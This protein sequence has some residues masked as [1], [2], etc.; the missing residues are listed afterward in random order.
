[1]KCQ[2]KKSRISVQKCISVQNPFKKLA[3]CQSPMPDHHYQ[4]FIKGFTA[5]I[6]ACHQ[7]QNLSVNFDD[8]VF[9]PYKLKQFFLRRVSNRCKEVEEFGNYFYGLIGLIVFNPTM[10]RV[11]LFSALLYN[12]TNSV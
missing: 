5:F 9:H 7:N 8:F 4:F 3:F 11:F 10:V 12:E 1:M 2:D 6:P